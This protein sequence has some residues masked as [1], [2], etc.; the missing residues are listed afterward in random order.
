MW[1]HPKLSLLISVGEATTCCLDNLGCTRNVAN[2]CRKSYKRLYFTKQGFKRQ[3]NILPQYKLT[4]SSKHGN[5][6]Q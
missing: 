5:K 3:L 6:I 1:V 2:T 4:V